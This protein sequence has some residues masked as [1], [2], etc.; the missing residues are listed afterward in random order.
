MYQVDTDVKSVTYTHVGV[1]HNDSLDRMI[2]NT[3]HSLFSCRSGTECEDEVYEIGARF[4]NYQQGHCEFS[5]GDA[6]ALAAAMGDEGFSMIARMLGLSEAE[7]ADGNAAWGLKSF[8]RLSNPR[9]RF[10]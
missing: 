4:S 10:I 8:S 1:C 7:P 6:T 5:H 3:R 2:H 9:V